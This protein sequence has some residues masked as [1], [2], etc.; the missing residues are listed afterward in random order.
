M[1]ARFKHSSSPPADW[2]LIVAVAIL[3]LLLLTPGMVARAS[4]VVCTLRTRTVVPGEEFDVHGP[5][6]LEVRAG[7]LV[8][9]EHEGERVILKPPDWGC[10]SLWLP[11][12]GVDEGA[13]SV[14]VFAGFECN[15]LGIRGL[16][17]L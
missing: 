12:T 11:I 1:F 13:G 8:V 16:L 2:I 9:V 7:K 17:G 10:E 5:R 14:E 15:S 6:L 4:K 3:A